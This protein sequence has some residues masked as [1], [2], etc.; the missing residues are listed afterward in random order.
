MDNVVDRLMVVK[1]DGLVRLFEGSYGE[2][3]VR[4][5]GSVEDAMLWCIIT[6]NMIDVPLTQCPEYECG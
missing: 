3:C 1:G 2:V 4:K 5:K 6:L